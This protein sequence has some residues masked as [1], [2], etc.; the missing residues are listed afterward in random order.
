MELYCFLRG[1]GTVRMCVTNNKFYKFSHASLL[2]INAEW[3]RREKLS[4]MGLKILSWKAKKYESWL[5]SFIE[6]FH[7]GLFVDFEW[8]FQNFLKAFERV[9]FK[10]NFEPILNDL[11]GNELNA[12][13]WTFLITLNELFESFSK[14]LGELF[15]NFEWATEWARVWAKNELFKSFLNAFWMPFKCFR[16]SIFKK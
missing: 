2:L 12:F 11:F 14:A 1:L 15:I 10:N 8:A 5:R 4:G 16:A 6:S 7:V 3:K 9:F 13:E